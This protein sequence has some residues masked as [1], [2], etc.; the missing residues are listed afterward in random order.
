MVEYVGK[1]SIQDMKDKKR[2]LQSI[3]RL[4]D[5]ASSK[6]LATLFELDNTMHFE[7]CV[8]IHLGDKFVVV[9]VTQ[10]P[11]LAD[12]ITNAA[13]D[14][15]SEAYRS[16]KAKAKPSMKPFSNGSDSD[17]KGVDVT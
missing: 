15:S 5:L 9:P 6:R 13:D 3:I 10:L 1:L 11:R 8:R 16:T 4:P 12:E 7:L 14:Y 2:E 17:G